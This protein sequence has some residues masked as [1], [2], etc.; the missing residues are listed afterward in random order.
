MPS[1]FDKSLKGVNVRHYKNTMNSPTVSMPVPDQVCIVMSQHMGKPCSVLVSVKDQVKVGQPI[2]NSDAS[3][4]AP[5]H[6]S[7]SGEVIRIDQITMPNGMRSAAVVI[8][9]DKQQTVFEKIAPPV[10]NDYPS[11]LQAIKDA[12]M[13]GLGGA[14]FPTHVKFSPRNLDE[15]NTLLVNAAECE[16]YIT[17]DY[18]TMIEDAESVLSGITMTMK[19]LELS[20]CIIGI[21]SN[22][23]AAIEKMRKLVESDPRIKVV[24]L[25]SKYPQGAEKVLIYE[26]TGKVVGEGMLPADVGVVVSNVTT[27]ASID[28]V[29]RTGMPLVSRRITVDGSAIMEPKNVLVP[30]GTP[31]ADIAAFCGGY[32][33]TPRKILM[34]GPMMGTAVYD[35]SYPVIKQNNALVFFDETQV[36][37]WDETACIRC[38]RCVRACPMNLMPLW[39]EDSYQRKD[40]EALMEF[41]VNLCMECGC[42]AYVCPAKRHLVLVHRL[43]KGMVRNH[44]TAQTGA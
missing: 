8:R 35:E 29:M 27:L 41:K 9:S 34:G 26:L 6:S 38:G 44:R 22:K 43:A 1:V 12:G 16:P 13:V 32:K 18:R 17:S 4:S 28:H 42:C 5:I 2:G 33:G 37:E 31:I 24:R 10:V 30:I 39:I 23:P 15:V 14:G 7:V 19:Y 3:F 25:S 36:E 11:F 40:V 20:Q 21:E